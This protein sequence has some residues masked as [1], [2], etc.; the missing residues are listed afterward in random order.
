MKDILYNPKKLQQANQNIERIL[1][2]KKEK[3]SFFLKIIK[4]FGTFKK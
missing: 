4:I 1:K 2:I 3:K